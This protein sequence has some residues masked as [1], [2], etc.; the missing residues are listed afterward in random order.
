MSRLS[1]KHAN[2]QNITFTDFSGGLNLT[3]ATEE[4]AQNEL[5]RSINLEIDSS[6]GLLKTVAG[7]KEIFKDDT[8]TFTDIVFDRISDTF[9]FVD[10][11][12][13]VYKYKDKTLTQVGTL[14]G[15]TQ[16]VYESWEDGVLIASGGKLQY[17]HDGALE[18]ISESPDANGVY[19]RSGR[20]IIYYGDTIRFS[21]IGDEHGWTDDTN[22]ASTSKWIEAGYKTGGNVIGM[23]NLSSDILIFKDN[24]RCYRLSGAFPNWTLQEVGRNIDCRSYNACVAL[25]DSALCLG[26]NSIQ[27]IVTTQTYGDMAAANIAAKVGSRIPLMPDGTKL[28]YIPE[29]QQ[30]WIITGEAHFM[31]YDVARQS[32]YDRE[33]NSK[34]V[35][36]VGAA[37][38]V[39]VLKEHGFYV[40]DN[41]VDMLDEGKLLYWSFE[42]KT[43]S[44]VNDI[45]VKRVR[46]DITPFFRH[47]ADIYFYI[48]DMEFSPRLP[49]VSR[50]V[51]GNNEHVWGNKRD[52]YSSDCK[53]R[54]YGT[55]IYGNRM[56]VKGGYSRVFEN[57]R[58]LA[59]LYNIKY[60][61]NGEYVYGDTD[62]VYGNTDYVCHVDCYRTDIRCVQRKAAIRVKGRG[63]GGMMLFNS[64]GMELAEV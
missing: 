37:G 23:C 28:R 12:R 56:S 36:V 33:F 24:R 55:R 25:T 62:F 18:T 17:Y 16:V 44:G 6:T 45:L 50:Y 11:A 57:K 1:N 30:V 5:S 42:A 61:H 10:S 26:R 27:G 49:W 39:Y 63:S 52:I 53:H 51:Y 31:F 48:G 9:L 35:D 40:L 59:K 13:A 14:T 32:F 29:L 41:D 8:K 47:G 15:K 21:N 34:V 19:I 58:R 46:A 38:N 22:D 64:I 54:F 2:A 3:N 43:I 20:V 60:S 7:T 4:I